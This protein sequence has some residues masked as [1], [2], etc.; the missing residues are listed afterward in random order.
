MGERTQEIVNGLKTWGP[1]DN[2]ATKTLF[3]LLSVLVTIALAWQNS[4]SHDVADLKTK[5]ANVA[6]DERVLEERVSGLKES[7]GRIESTLNQ[8]NSRLNTVLQERRP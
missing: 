2:I 1:R 4:V 5:H 3:L 8:V 6:A 7:L